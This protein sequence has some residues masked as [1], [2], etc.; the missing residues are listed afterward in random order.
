MSETQ[1]KQAWITS[2]RLLASTPKSSSELEA[3][4][5]EKGY[6][7]EVVRAT[8]EGLRS[9]GLLDD[10]AFA[11]QIA[12]RLTAG[13][14]SGNR[15]IAFELKRRRVPAPVREEILEGLTEES[16]RERARET[17]K[18][19]WEKWAALAPDKRKKR[20]YDFLARR[21]FDFTVAR[22]VVEE[23]SRAVTDAHR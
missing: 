12:S 16:E 4:L 9:K 8:V 10:E 6:P 15:R 22:E 11:R 19:K 21:G 3:K 1:I 18:D 20:T 14:P 23:L 7:A 5:A 17:A 2:L 13:K